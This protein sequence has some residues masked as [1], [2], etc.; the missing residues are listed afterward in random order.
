MQDLLTAPASRAKS[1]H[2]GTRVYDA[3]QMGYA[4]EGAYVLDTAGPGNSN[5][6]HDY[7]TDLST[8]QKRELIEYLKTL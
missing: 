8:D 5:A 6:G 7:G 4:D 3:A 1:F 2:R